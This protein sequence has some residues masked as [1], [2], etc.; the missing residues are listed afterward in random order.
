M[1]NNR[2]IP[3]YLFTGFLGAGKTTFIQDILSSEEF[4][5]GENTLLLLCEEG[6]VEYETEKFAFP[7][8]LV[9][10]IDE[11]KDLTKA[12]LAHLAKEAQAERVIVEYNGMWMLESLFRNMPPEWIIYQEVTFADATTFLMYNQ[13]MR[14]LTFDKMKTAE[15]DIFNRCVRG[16]DKMAFHKEVRVANRRAQILYEYGPDDV[17]PDDIADPLPY[18]MD[19][20]EIEIKDEDYAEW[21]R[22]INENPGRYDG[23]TLI[24]KVRAAMVEE[25]PRGEF[26]AGRHVMTC[27][28]ED[29]QFAALVY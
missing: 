14:Q 19:A 23:K 17:E 12:N 15:L 16:F 11:E 1:D 24:L 26:A 8:V 18:D 7:N 28:V 21:Y 6:E 25:M 29:I 27:C 13:N 10:A 3:V 2:D 5:E 9:A 4:N 22:D 20:P